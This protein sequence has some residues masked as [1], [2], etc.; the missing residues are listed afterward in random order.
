MLTLKAEGP[1]GDFFD[2][3][4]VVH[5]G[6]AFHIVYAKKLRSDDISPTYSYHLEHFR[7]PLGQQADGYFI[8][9]YDPAVADPP[10]ISHPEAALA[11]YRNKLVV[12]YRDPTGWVRYA[13]W[14][15]AD[16]QAPWLGTGIVDA[17]HRTR[18]RPALGVFHNR[19]NLSGPDWGQS[20]FGD[21]L[22]A[23]ITEISTDAILHVNFSRALFSNEIAAQFVAYDSNSDDESV[24]CRPQNDPLAPTKV[25]DMGADGRPFFSELGYVLWTFP[26]WF[27]GNLYA[28]AGRLGC[29]ANNTSGRFTPPCDSARYPVILRSKGGAFICNGIWVWQGEVYSWNI[30]HELAHSM[31]GMLGFSDGGGPAPTSGNALNTGIALSALTAGYTLFGSQVNADCLSNEAS[32]TCPNSRATG[33]T[34]YGNNYDVSTRQ[35]AFIGAL[36]YYFYDGAQLREW[37]Q[38]DAKAGSTLLQQKYSWIKQNIFKGVEFEQDN[39][40]LKQTLSPPNAQ[41]F[42]VYEP[43]VACR[44]SPLPSVAQP[45]GVGSIAEGGSTLSLELGTLE[46]T[47]NV[48]IYLALYLPALDANN[49]YLIHS[50]LSLHNASAGMVPWRSNTAGPVDYSLFG[51]LPLSGLSGFGG[52]IGLLVTP[53]GDLTKNYF[54]ATSFLVP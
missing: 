28:T 21:D 42:H 45:I 15:N 3:S 25:T 46:F 9:A 31:A 17:S 39:L 33:F 38:A 44:K 27:I 2:L 16:P 13:R 26:N 47:D 14:D 20:N 43:A 54:W 19:S 18:H 6:G 52:L 50:D 29:E 22:I 48:D 37:I 49:I 8:S 1:Q 12:A 23:A 35:H 32:D 36:Y 10:G 51:D 53:A 7:I 40:P 5:F 24:V 41:E 11:V 34:G 30:F 4:N